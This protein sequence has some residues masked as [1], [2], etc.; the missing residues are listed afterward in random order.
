MDTL[1]SNLFNPPYISHFLL[2]LVLASSYL[3]TSSHFCFCLVD[4][5]PS[6]GTV[7]S[8]IE[9]ERSALLSFKQDLKDPSGRLSSWAG[10]DCC[11]WQGISCNNRNGHVAKLNLRNPYPYVGHDEEWDEL[12]YNQSCLGGKIN[13]SLLSLKYLNYLDLS[14]NDFDGIHIPKFFGELKSLRYLNISHAS[15]SGEIPPS[16]GN[17]SKLNYLDF[18]ISSDY[19]TTMHSKSLNWLSHL[20]SLKYLNLNR[21]N[22]SN[23]G[24]P[25]VMHHLNMLPS[26]L[27]LHLSY[28]FLESFQLSPQ[29]INFTFPLSLQKINFTSLSVLDLSSN[30]FN[31]S[32]PSWLFNLTSLRKLDLSG[33]Y[34]GGPFPDELASLKSGIPRFS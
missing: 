12:A 27:E 10:R 31:T 6:T 21:V 18:D 20:S 28:C 22:L 13:P 26:L 32:F 1:Y 14:Y 7:R 15:F 33:N 24:V 29:K 9:E 3:H 11:Q 16:F 2:L 25:N 17:L 34:L 5:V 4:G 23:T 30:Y 8:C 19:A